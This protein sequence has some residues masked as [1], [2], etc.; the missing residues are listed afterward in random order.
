[1]TDLWCT[2]GPV[3]ETNGIDGADEAHDR[4]VARDDEFR[5]VI[6]TATFAPAE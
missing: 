4:V 3:I 5:P 1:M 2:G 6:D